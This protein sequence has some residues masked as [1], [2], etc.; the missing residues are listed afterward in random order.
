M[1]ADRGARQLWMK[2]GDLSKE[3]GMWVVLPTRARGIDISMGVRIIIPTKFKIL[4]KLHAHTYFG[5][6]RENPRE[7]DG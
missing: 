1:W 5:R 3:A 4:Y 6:L 7:L 2:S